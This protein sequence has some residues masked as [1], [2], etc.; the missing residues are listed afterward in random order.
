MGPVLDIPLHARRDG[1]A[2]T[3][4]F[5]KLLKKQG[6]RPRVPVTDQLGSYQV[7]HRNMM[8]SVEHRQSKCSNNPAENSHQSGRECRHDLRA[9]TPVCEKLHR[10]LLRWSTRVVRS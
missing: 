5:R 8:S 2:A 4:F 6:C 9:C 10:R 3:P 1:R 7:A